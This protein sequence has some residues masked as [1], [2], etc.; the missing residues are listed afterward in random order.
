M[1]AA[2]R[3]AN[4]GAVTHPVTLPTRA[5]TLGVGSSRTARPRRGHAARLGLR[6]RCLAHGSRGGSR[7]DLCRLDGRHDPPARPRRVPPRTRRP[8]RPPCPGR[9]ARHGSR[10]RRRRPAGHERRASPARRC[11]PDQL[12]RGRRLGRAPAS[13]AD[14]RAP[15]AGA[16]PG[17]GGR[18]CEARTLL[19]H[20]R[21]LGRRARRLRR[22]S[23]ARG[24]A[25]PGRA[26]QSRPGRPRPPDRRD[27]PDREPPPPAAARAPAR[28]RR[29][30]R[31]ARAQRSLRARLRVRPGRGDQRRLVHRGARRCIAGCRTRSPAASSTS[32][33]RSSPQSSSRR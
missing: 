9:H 25:D 24:R 28:R 18:G 6:V 7:L 14:D 13:H 2:P 26:R 5:V 27:R 10:R 16:G 19:R 21:G 22:Q 33:S 4:V 23:L 3:A 31:G 15:S 20:A 17:R 30:A 29:H 1:A 12:P 8:S 11:I 32:S